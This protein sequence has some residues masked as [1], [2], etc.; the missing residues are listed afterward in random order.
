[1]YWKI[2]AVHIDGIWNSGGLLT[3]GAKS[4][5]AAR[6]KAAEWHASLPHY[7]QS[8]V[9]IHSVSIIRRAQ[10]APRKGE[11]KSGAILLASNVTVE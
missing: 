10:Y 9:D 5:K 7:D 4:K 2:Y 11:I 6:K 1:M 8:A 3:I